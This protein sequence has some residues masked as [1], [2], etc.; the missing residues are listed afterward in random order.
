MALHP[1]KLP[2]SAQDLR[3]IVAMQKLLLK[4]LC[5]DPLDAS[6]I[7]ETWLRS[8]WSFQDEAWLK[9]FCRKR[10]YSILEPIAEIAKAT[11]DARRALYDEFCRQIRVKQFLETGGQFRKL[12][13][14]TGVT[15]DLAKQ[16]HSVFIR[17]YEF[18]SHEAKA[19][20]NGYE[21]TDG[22]VV[23][24][25]S[26]KMALDD[27]NRPEL[28]VC[29]YCDGS[30]DDPDLD[31]YYAKEAYPFL[32]CSPWNLVPA[33]SYC[34]KLSAKGRELAL[35]LGVAEPTAEWFHPF[36]RPATNAVEIRLSGAPKNSIPQLY[37][38]DPTEQQ[39]LN[40]HTALIRTLGTRWTKV[41]KVSFDRLVRDTIN[42]VKD[43]GDPI[44]TI[45][46][47]RLRDHR[48]SRG[49]DASSLI[50]AAVCQ[51]VLD[52]RPEYLE[53]FSTPNSAKLEML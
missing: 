28:A 13:T 51:A 52:Q 35:T 39:R 2:K 22:H 1:V 45:V 5:A 25:D 4:A 37:S 50:H 16:V 53:A 27:A 33:C 15:S 32:S 21:F 20:W 49:R 19:G 24:N 14:L 36:I 3:R 34:N 26:Y 40:N 30:N 18:L 6:L 29:P 31:H 41:V 9:K 8:V 7:N 11:L 12:D 17:F 47:R 10:K 46:R 42:A 23:R 43:T 44:E 38:P 48:L